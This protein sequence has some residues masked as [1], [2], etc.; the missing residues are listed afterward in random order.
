MPLKRVTFGTSVKPLG[1]NKVSV[2]PNTN[3]LF[4]M[5]DRNPAFKYIAWDDNIKRT[6]DI[7]SDPTDPN[8][9]LIPKGVLSKARAISMYLVAKL[10][11]DAQLNIIGDNF[12]VQYLVLNP[13]NND[14]FISATHVNP[15][16][17]SISITKED[18]KD[19]KGR[20]VGQLI[21][22]PATLAIPQTITA[23]I[24]QLVQKEGAL[25]ALWEKVDGATSTPVEECLQLAQSKL[26]EAN[27][28]LPQGQAP[29]QP[30]QLSAVPS[31]VNRGIGAPQ[32]PQ[33]FG[34]APQQAYAQ[35]VVQDTNAFQ[36]ETL[37]F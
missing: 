17:T 11:T 35:G 26:A 10:N 4:V 8:L 28:A 33:S 1:I 14:K 16:Y 25:D 32:A 5:V 29:Q 31:D 2:A 24:A 19:D 22:T 36:D 6:W 7:P 15:N 37:P 12:E 21:I 13:T 30:V 18:K 23:K 20:D 34:Q 3:Q 27:Q 9:A